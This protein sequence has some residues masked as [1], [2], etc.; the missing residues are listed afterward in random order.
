MRV[1]ALLL[2]LTAT[3]TASAQ[4][5]PTVQF[6]T[7]A[8]MVAYSIPASSTRLTA[9]VSGRLT[10]NDGFGGTF[11]YQAGTSALTNLGTVF[12]PNTATGRWFRQV[13]G[14]EA[15]NIGWFGADPSGT[16]ES[17]TPLQN[18]IDTSTM[19][20]PAVYIPAGT[21]RIS[22]SINTLRRG[23]IYG[24]GKDR[25]FLNS[26]IDIDNAPLFFYPANSD[27]VILR[28]LAL[29]NARTTGTNRVTGVLCDV[30]TSSTHLYFD[31]V[32]FEKWTRYAF[33]S[34]TSF[35]VD[36]NQ[37]NF[38]RNNN[39]T[40][41]GGTDVLGAS[42]ISID[43]NANTVNIIQCRFGFSDQFLDITQGHQFLSLG[44]SYELGGTVQRGGWTPGY[45][46]DIGLSRFSEFNFVFNYV[47]GNVTATNKAAL[48]IQNCQSPNVNYNDWFGSFGGTNLTHNFIEVGTNVFS[49][50]PTGNNFED[51][52]NYAVN[53]VSTSPVKAYGNTI[54]RNGS[55][56]DDK[57]NQRPFYHNCFIDGDTYVKAGNENAYAFDQFSASS[58]TNSVVWTRLRTTNTVGSTLPG[59][60]TGFT[61]HLPRDTG[62]IGEVAS[63]SWVFT[64]TAL[65]L[66]DTDTVITN[67]R[68]ST[69]QETLRVVSDGT[70]RLSGGT[71]FLHGSGTPEGS[72]TAPVGSFYLRTN[73]GSGTIAYTKIF[74]TG[75][76]GWEALTGGGGTIIGASNLGGGV[77]VFAGTTGSTNLS[78]N[79][80]AGTN[81][82][83]VVSNANVITV[84]TT[85][86]AGVTNSSGSLSAN[87]AAGSNIT[88]TTG[89][90]GQITI[91]AAGGGAGSTNAIYVNGVAVNGPNFTN[92][93]GGNFAVTGTNVTFTPA[94]S[95]GT[96]TIT[97][98]S[99][100]GTGVGTFAGTT[101]STNLS[102]NSIAAAQGLAV[103]SNANTITLY[104]PTLANVGSG[105]GVYAGAT[106]TGSTNHTFNSL[107][108]GTTVVVSSNASTLTISGPIAS[109]VGTGIGLYAGTT[110]STNFTFN[111]L[112]G[113][114]GITISSNASTVTASLTVTNYVTIA[115]SNPNTTVTTGNT[116]FWVA[117]AAGTIKSVKGILFQPSTSGSVT[118]ELKKNGTTVLSAAATMASGATNATPT[119]SVTS[120]SALDRLAGEVTGAGTDAYGA[121]L[122]IGYTLP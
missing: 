85:T 71:L 117:P 91:D 46:L 68:N 102:F 10:T 72:I 59:Y 67:A 89:A 31:N 29:I 4:V 57:V 79:S 30:G 115:L 21:Y 114:N 38:Y 60:G 58:Q 90:N 5:T 6:K 69:L 45:F 3:L 65:G 37:C 34:P 66:E 73:G 13:E 24:D 54:Y 101:G 39:I 26:Y 77:G 49:F 22:T 108:G 118:L 50:M 32:W 14:T 9:I 99:N 33:K 106:G 27:N 7:V 19:T 11:I 56:I 80:L 105:T 17:A 122:Q 103:Q 61:I 48:R 83:T 111:S 86:G 88:L 74:G 12:K 110:S 98:A 120:F 81:G 55:I 64:E 16:L 78:L 100:L 42:D 97:G 36:F 84:G 82:I 70:L 52:I 109:N 94:A 116:N 41:Y 44:S 63:L 15:L 92:S 2:L 104:G 23:L 40:A 8:D 20:G 119:V 62:D 113:A 51:Q 107:T 25:T 112:T 93:A 96:G 76:T 1:I 53:S 43:A 87:L 121:Q 18:A 75:N 35:Y 95:G 47:E 28:G